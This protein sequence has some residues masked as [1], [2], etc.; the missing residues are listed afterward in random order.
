MGM[1]P[2]AG[3]GLLA[4]I[5]WPVAHSL[6]PVMHNAGFRRLGWNLCYL[7][8]AVPPEPGEVAAAVKGLRALGSR[9]FNV[10]VPHK[11]A[12][13]KLVD[14][15]DHSATQVGA[16]NTVAVR[17]GSL[18]G[19]NTD[20]LGFIASL[21]EQGFDPKGHSVLVFGAGG[22]ARGVVA[23][24]VQA[25]VRRVVVANRSP[26]KAQRLVEDVRSFQPLAEIQAVP[27]EYAC[28]VRQAQG[29]TLVINTTSVGLNPEDPPVWTDFSIFDS[30]SL[31][32]DLIYHSETT[33]FL[34]LANEAGFRTMNGLGMLVHQA[35]L[36]WQVWFGE[37]GPVDVFY[38]AARSALRER[39][40]GADHKRKE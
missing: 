32:V 7:A 30:R 38:D 4:L 25:G 18:V 22:A 29:V 11:E 36:S 10:T 14:E 5:G 20:G 35:A 19:Y 9:G 21:K 31:V 16:V 1:L 12:V 39:G 2:D 37:P 6:S 23:A 27:L 15:L 40:S 13:A 28:V 3:T 8:F 24:M 33:P 34:A 26:D 17:Q